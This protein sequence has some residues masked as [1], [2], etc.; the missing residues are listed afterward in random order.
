MQ[1]RYVDEAPPVRTRVQTMVDVEEEENIPIL[2]DTTK[3]ES[4][5]GDEEVTSISISPACSS[6]TRSQHI[7]S[8]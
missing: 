7:S 1:G 3:E 2:E 6:S 8:H 5:V 4:M